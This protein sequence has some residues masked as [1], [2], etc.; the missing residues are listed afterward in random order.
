MSD[1]TISIVN[2]CQKNLLNRCL[3]QINTL[4]LPSSWHTVVV[5]NNSSD[6]SADMVSKNYPWVK[7]T[8][9]GKNLGFGGGHN[10]AY[11]HS[12]SNIFIVLNPDVIV[13]PGSLET[14]IE[15]F[16]RFPKTAIVGPCLLNPNGTPQ[17]SARRFYTWR[18]VACR[19]LPIPGRQKVNDYHLMKD[20]DLSQLLSV[21]WLLGAAMC[22]RSSAF[23]ER[24]LFD[25]RYKLYFED[26]DLC[27]FAK[28][29]GWDV[30][31]CPQSRMIHDHQR[32]SAKTFGSTAKIK[33]FTSWIKFYLKTKACLEVTQPA[34]SQFS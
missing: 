13:L 10:T 9:L 5:D 17:F 3:A 28:K 4:A 16:E 25:T 33:H 11:A 15:T 8:R 34:I 23:D 21:D 30:L 20:C 6:G 26:V 27:Y 31:Y 7:L 22:I 24:E 32:T 18:T 1:V 12:D 29:R 19:R 14:L 2:Y